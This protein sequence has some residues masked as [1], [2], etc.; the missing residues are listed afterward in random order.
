M[1]FPWMLTSTLLIISTLGLI[2][3]HAG[4]K[5]SLEAKCSFDETNVGIFIADTKEMATNIADGDQ[6]QKVQSGLKEVQSMMD[7]LYENLNSIGKMDIYDVGL[8]FNKSWFE[9][10]KS[11]INDLIGSIK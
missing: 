3:V 10:T 8:E 6:A 1:R 9:E 2:S 5:C 7:Q 11:R 4:S